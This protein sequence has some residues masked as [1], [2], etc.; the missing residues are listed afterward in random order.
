ML[1]IAD[2]CVGH[3][4]PPFI[5][6]ELSG[7]HGGSIERALAT[8]DAIGEIGWRVHDVDNEEDWVHAEMMHSYSRGQANNG[9]AQ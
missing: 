6:A 1:K 8:V 5:I 2:C 3:K 7:N 4:A 9:I